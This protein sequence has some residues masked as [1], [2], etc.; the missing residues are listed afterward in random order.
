MP[1]ATVELIRVTGVSPYSVFAGS[2][3]YSFNKGITSGQFQKGHAYSVTVTVGKNGNKYINGVTNDLGVLDADISQVSVPT[4]NKENTPLNPE[5][6]VLVSRPVNEYGKPVSDY[7]IAKD[8]RIARSGVIQAAV[9]AV[10][11]HVKDVD[12]LKLKARELAEDML[13]WV[14]NSQGPV[15]D[16]QSKS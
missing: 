11:S 7:A 16:S 10:S 6:N 5:T 12:E 1:N 14:N 2:T 9:Q 8:G 4:T 13:L 15:S 3:R